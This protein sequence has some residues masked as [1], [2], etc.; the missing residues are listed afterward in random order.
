MKPLVMAKQEG[1]YDRGGQIRP[2]ATWLVYYLVIGSLSASTALG[3]C[4]TP[5]SGSSCSR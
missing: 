5:P 2:L 4:S 3:S 1:G